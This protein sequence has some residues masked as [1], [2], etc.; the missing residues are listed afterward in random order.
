MNSWAELQ[1]V[2][3]T[4]TEIFITESE[5]ERMDQVLSLLPANTRTVLE[6]GARHGVMTQKLAERCHS[7][8]ALDL[9]RPSFQIDRVTPVQG[10][11]QKLEFPDDSF[12]C[13]VCT[14]VLEH[15]PNVN[16]GAQ[17]IV[18][19]AKSHILIGVPY[20]QDRR[21][22][23][24]T[25]GHCGKI[26]PPYGHLNA[27]D[28]RTIERLFP[29]AS[30]SR[31]RFVSTNRERTNGVAT[32]LQ[33]MAR[34]PYGAYDQEEPCIYCNRKL[35]WRPTNS[36]LR[37]MAGAAGVRLYEMQAAVNRP[38]PTWM[39]V[40]FEKK[41]GE[42][43]QRRGNY[44]FAPHPRPDV[45]PAFPGQEAE[46]GQT[47]LNCMKEMEESEREL[48]FVWRSCRA[49]RK[50]PESVVI[51][52]TIHTR[53]GEITTNRYP[54]LFLPEEAMTEETIRI[55]AGE[56]KAF[57]KYDAD[58]VLYSAEGHEQVGQWQFVRQSDGEIRQSHTMPSCAH[59][60]LHLAN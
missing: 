28:E 52:E 54:T 56:R 25:C 17:E 1:T 58:S 13:V 14:E 31:T 12:D 60:H 27:F 4:T 46:T 49:Q 8:T 9:Q 59:L 36:F 50:D 26:N 41:H 35:E 53:T 57:E 6:I 11:V 10:D 44:N 37:R 33:D 16:A 47:S 39:L 48:F 43:K 18:R 51:V 38:L 7:V 21:V 42:E 32:W 2:A 22:G 40:R 45:I 5:K 19:V 24:M 23:R 3:G 30:V 29:A 55:F 34:N 15:L 20:R